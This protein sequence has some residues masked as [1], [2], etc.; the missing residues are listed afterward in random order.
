MRQMLR[1][2]GV[3]PHLEN[4]ESKDSANWIQGKNQIHC[5]EEGKENEIDN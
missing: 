5:Q 4:E 3:W 1:N 2:M